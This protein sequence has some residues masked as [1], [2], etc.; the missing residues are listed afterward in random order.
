LKCLN[1]SNDSKLILY[2]LFFPSK[3]IFFMVY[4]SI[5]SAKTN[6]KPED[7][8]RKMPIGT[9]AGYYN[10]CGSVQGGNETERVRANLRTYV[11]SGY[12]S[13]HEKLV[14]ALAKELSQTLK[15]KGINPEEKDLSVLCEKI[16]KSLPIEA[17]N[18]AP[19]LD[20]KVHKSLTVK[21]AEA[22]NKAYGGMV[23]DTN[24]DADV[25]ISQVL[26]LLSTLCAGLGGEFAAVK[27]EVRRI[28]KNLKDLAL[29]LQRNYNTLLQ[30]VE[31]S[32]DPTLKSQSSAIREV[33]KLLK[34]ENDRQ[35]AMMQNLFNTIVEPTDTDVSVILEKNKELLPLI[36]R[37]KDQPGTKSYS[38]KLMA[39]L[40]GAGNVAMMAKDVHSALRKIGM[41]LSDYEK[42][43]DLR[44]L[45]KKANGLLEASGKLKN[46]SLEEL[47]QFMQAVDVLRNSEYYR[48]D[49]SKTLH[50]GGDEVVGGRYKGVAKRIKKR[51]KLRDSIFRGYNAELGTIF[52]DMVDKLEKVSR[53]MG[54]TIVVTEQLDQLVNALTN[55]PDIAKKYIYYSLSGYVDDTVSRARREFF[56]NQLNYSVHCI[57]RILKMESYKNQHDVLNGLRRSIIGVLE[58]VKRFKEYFSSGWKIASM[59]AKRGANENISAADV[60]SARRQGEGLQHEQAHS[61]PGQ[62]TAQQVDLFQSGM[63]KA[64]VQGGALDDVQI[65]EVTKSAY[66]LREVLNNMR[67]FYNLAKARYNLSKAASEVSEAE[68]DYTAI[69]GD[70]IGKKLESITNLHVSSDPNSAKSRIALLKQSGNLT[71]KQAAALEEFN[72]DVFS[73]KRDMYRT[74]EAIEVYLQKFTSA[75]S[76]HP[77]EVQALKEVLDSVQLAAK[78]FSNESGDRLAD[79]FD[80]F[81]QYMD[82]VSG[83]PVASEVETESGVHYYQKIENAVTAA[84]GAD[85]GLPGIPFLPIDIEMAAQAKKKAER[86]VRS[87]T[88][89]KNLVSAFISIGSKFDGKELRKQTHMTDKQIYENLAN[90][91]WVS[92]F[93]SGI[94][95]DSG[96]RNVPQ[97]ATGYAEHG[98]PDTNIGRDLSGA[99]A[100][101][102]RNALNM[103]QVTM[104]GYLDQQT[105]G[106]LRNPAKLRLNSTFEET[107][108]LWLMVV[109]AL[110]VKPLVVTGVYNLFNRPEI[111]KQELGATRMVL[112][113]SENPKVE[114]D[115]IPLY[116]R[117]PL[118]AEFYR[119]VFN[120]EGFT[121]TYAVSM[122]P[123]GDDLFAGFIELMFNQTRHVQSG[124]YSESQVRG[125]VEEVNRI[126]ARFGSKKDT[127]VTDIINEFVAEVNRRYGLVE[128]SDREAY[129]KERRMLN[130]ADRDYKNDLLDDDYP[131]LEGED[132]PNI[133]MPAPSDAYMGVTT[134]NYQTDATLDLGEKK[135]IN[136]FR[137]K[138]DALLYK[139]EI[140]ADTQDYQFNAS[141]YQ[142][143][144][145]LASLNDDKSRF[146]VVL[147][148]V[149]GVGRFLRHGGVKMIM[150]GETVVNSLNLL[151]AVYSELNAYRSLVLEYNAGGLEQDIRAYLSDENDIAAG[152][153]FHTDLVNFI[154]KREE[155]ELYYRRY[156]SQRDVQRYVDNCLPGLVGSGTTLTRTSGQFGLC[157]ADLTGLS[158]NRISP[159][160]FANDDLSPTARG[161]ITTVMRHL[162]VDRIFGRIHSVLF[163]QGCD[164]NKLVALRVMGGENND[165][166]LMIDHSN[167][168]ARI[169][170]LF[171]G[172]KEMFEKFRS[173]IPADDITRYERNDKGSLYFLEEKLMDELI[174]GADA[175]TL[176]PISLD[177]VDGYVSAT[178]RVLVDNRRNNVAVIMQQEIL[179][180]SAA[181]A[182]NVPLAGRVGALTVLTPIAGITYPSAAV[183]A[184]NPE[185]YNVSNSFTATSRSAFF[186]F[187]ELLFKYLDLIFDGAAQKVYR[188]CIDN[189][190]GGTFS[191]SITDPNNNS[192]DDITPAAPFAGA[193]VVTPARVMTR[194]NAL[195]M[196][197]LMNSTTNQAKPAFLVQELA[198]VP[199]H[200]KERFRANFPFVIKVADTLIRRCE[201]DK[202]YVQSGLS[203]GPNPDVLVQILNKIGQGLFAIRNSA[204]DVLKE[205]DDQ[206][207]YFEVSRGS[208]D[209]AK[210][211]SGQ[212]PVMPLSST[213]TLLKNVLPGAPDAFNS[214]PLLPFSTQ[215]QN[216]FKLRYG[217]RQLLGRPDS[218]VS[219]DKLPWM[220]ELLQAYNGVSEARGQ[221]EEAKCNTHVSRH[222]ELLR[223]LTDARHI[224]DNMVSGG[225]AARLATLPSLANA[226]GDGDAFG[227]YNPAPV[228]GAPAL[229]SSVYSLKDN[230]AFDDVLAMTESTFD[231][232]MRTKLAQAV[233]SSS[234]ALTRNQVAV[235]NLLDMNIV[236]INIR[237]LMREVS[238]I[239]LYN[240]SYTWDH[241]VSEMFGYHP[242]M[243]LTD[244]TAKV[245]PAEL[246][247]PKDVFV[248]LLVQP[249]QELDYMTYQ[250]YVPLIMS[251]VIDLGLGRPKFLGDQFYNKALLG[252][253]YN[254]VN[255]YIGTRFDGQQTYH[256]R[257][258][259]GRDRGYGLGPDVAQSNAAIGANP[260]VARA[261]FKSRLPVG[262]PTP[263]NIRPNF[264]FLKDTQKDWADRV[265]EVNVGARA[266]QALMVIGK[267]RFDT[268]FARNIT[269]LV[270]CQRVLRLKLHQELSW[271]KRVVSGTT[272]VDPKLTEVSGDNSSYDDDQNKGQQLGKYKL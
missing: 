195:I 215:G 183:A 54:K 89:L 266:K 171:E 170:E 213:L 165:G 272:I 148:A 52:D 93:V 140:T 10:N 163:D 239:N 43:K 49:I 96:Q 129:R 168:K 47:G 35:L 30:K 125:I 16:M 80:E 134:R 116:V 226:V 45:E 185:L 97:S 230:T 72:K 265:S 5:S 92:A 234:A 178:L 166:T 216:S 218:E 105:D 128:N 123:E 98:L 27:S 177:Q 144:Q 147:S 110:V 164:L 20:S 132:E 65:P 224:R 158:G 90:Y 212:L 248:R 247:N 257:L 28:I 151:G 150:F 26:E 126:Y 120:F 61:S 255:Q 109:K 133:R 112:G 169:E 172:T 78:W 199:D 50:K 167:L 64:D 184:Y 6:G 74:A 24:Q 161:V 76:K 241:M 182:A 104:D 42:A 179:G 70:S 242:S 15:I 95:G 256:D 122:V 32:S 152:T 1:I 113:G 124:F 180:F 56:I 233:T 73:V 117:L 135:V 60:K 142:A 57:E 155:S 220:K 138:I 229:S 12:E 196:R 115:L 231:D 176:R 207:K 264:T 51:R 271:D 238:L 119:E 194:T 46:P 21:F 34:A 149:Q 102:A 107:D 192:F 227:I 173:S 139:E 100:G 193:A 91:L 111:R 22:V 197:N 210:S 200:M 246:R 211:L 252:E 44:E 17:N 81:P 262:V 214:Y 103:R 136:E 245:N 188:K 40:L 131:I 154:W 160:E 243:S 59:D 4:I 127:V 174:R 31:D 250:V 75:I 87:L 13:A 209:Y 228:R 19:K 186:L 85:L 25:V 48:G 82:P 156:A 175:D 77:E 187:N 260:S 79:V 201:L 270:M 258:G 8:L 237:A 58:V 189:I 269:F 225:L 232:N 88:V 137:R 86:A 53:Q 141:I 249:H 2:L 11:G 251:G 37:L 219:L 55:I 221:I 83:D 130:G 23:I 244:D 84:G 33:Y 240:L 7:F 67:Y 205:L 14:R 71:A 198:D 190:S 191:D 38:Q 9:I 181:A 121:G 145:E 203:I 36:K 202:A 253:L 99:A 236:P 206:P 69:L 101:D 66:K 254:G 63:T 68:E 267:F 261:S 235:R 208:L 162:D 263:L 223:Y 106:A 222:V 3:E 94:E 157:S 159:K 62:F 41:S 29:L 268:K 18:N 118:L 204:A 39:G 146:N 143:Q 217:V 108:R 114:S 259:L 153:V